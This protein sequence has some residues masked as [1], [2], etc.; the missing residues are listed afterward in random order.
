MFSDLRIC[1]FTMNKLLNVHFQET[2]FILRA[3]FDSVQ[4][5]FFKLVE[6]RSHAHGYIVGL[7]H[8]VRVG[9]HALLSYTKVNS[10][11]VC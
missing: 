11:F 5:S 2:L 1:N 10:Y 8:T 9:R 6:N 4:L 7:Q 3:K